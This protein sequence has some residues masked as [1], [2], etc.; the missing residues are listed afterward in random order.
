MTGEGIASVLTSLA[1]L[2]GVVGGI[3]VQLRGQTEARAGREKLNEKIDVNTAVTNDTAAKVEVVHAATTAI[4]ES[5][6]AHPVLK[7]PDP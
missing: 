2:V 1:T 4:V 6:G 3:V 5:T 7:Q